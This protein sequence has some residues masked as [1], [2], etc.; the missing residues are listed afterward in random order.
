MDGI[1]YNLDEKLETETHFL[2]PFYF[3]HYKQCTGYRE[4]LSLLEN[5]SK[6]ALCI[7]FKGSIDNSPEGCH[8]MVIVWNP[9]TRCEATITD[10]EVMAEIIT[11]RDIV[12]EDYDHINKNDKL[13]EMFIQRK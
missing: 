10:H 6:L 7:S 11:Q 1:K 12:I 9:A 5:G 8:K 2:L 3:N 4:K 13:K